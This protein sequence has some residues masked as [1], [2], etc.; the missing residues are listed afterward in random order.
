[1]AWALDREGKRV[2]AALLARERR[3]ELAPFACP[4]CGEE[5]VAK[6]GARRARHFAHRPGS[7]CALTR[8]ETLLHFNAKERLLFLCEEAF[9]G[10]MAVLLRARCPTCRRE[11]P[12]QLAAAGDAAIGEGS[13]GALRADVLVT[14]GGSPALAFEVRVTHAIDA[15]KEAA[16]AK[17][18]LPALEL[19]AREPWEEELPGGVALRVA[20]TIGVPT[21]PSCQ[22]SARAEAERAQ[23]GEA[24]EVAELEAYRARGLLGPPPGPA[25]GA[26]EPLSACEQSRLTASF[27]CP[28][29]GGR[30]LAVG[31][32][33]LRHACPG[34]TPRPVAW[35]GY[36]GSLVELAWWRRVP[37]QGS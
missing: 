33:L 25:L 28:E 9:S 19:D 5:L 24:A 20:R 31:A 3:K 29:C 30:E 8:P 2:Q 17:L 16:L 13:A 15:A 23:G 4:G 35:R 34:Q 32:R 22:A 37:G 10:R 27:R 18:A 1:M 36:D 14:R 6:L 26:S 12:I 11:T 21:C 7:S